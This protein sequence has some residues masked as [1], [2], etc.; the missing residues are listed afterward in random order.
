M[1]SL[2]QNKELADL[3]EKMKINT[4][5]AFNRLKERKREMIIEP[6]RY[7]SQNFKFNQFEGVYDIQK[8][9]LE[10]AANEIRKQREDQV[11]DRLAKLG[12][13]FETREQFYDFAKARLTLVTS[14]M[15]PNYFELYL[16][17]GGICVATWWNTFKI[18]QEENRFTILSGEPE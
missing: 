14:E 12:F 13:K 5:N 18:N 4:D 9:I 6:V 1:A 8:S 7:E 3:I 11:M 17:N 16:D 10:K 2:Q 15:N